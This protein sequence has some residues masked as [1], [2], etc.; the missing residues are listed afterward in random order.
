MAR[1]K[2][3]GQEVPDNKITF[4]QT[5]DTH[6]DILL[7]GQVVGDVWSELPNGCE[8]A[9]GKGTIQ[10]CGFNKKPQV[11]DCGRFRGKKDLC[12]D[13]KKVI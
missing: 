6:V 5:S 12:L 8:P 2:E 10:I 1:C 3:C 7:D 9:Y 13:F 11:W 4:Q